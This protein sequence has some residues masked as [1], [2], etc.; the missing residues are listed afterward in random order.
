VVLR[1]SVL[2]LQVFPI[3]QQVQSAHPELAPLIR[4][5]D[6][7]MTIVVIYEALFA[8]HPQ[9]MC[10]KADH[11]WHTIWQRALSA[12]CPPFG[13]AVFASP[14]E[15]QTLPAHPT[16]SYAQSVKA[17]C[18]EAFAGLLPVLE[19][20][21]ARRPG[22][23]GLFD[24]TVVTMER[25]KWAWAVQSRC[26][27]DVQAELPAAEAASLHEKMAAERATS[28]GLVAAPASASAAEASA[29]ARGGE[30][31]GKP[32]RARARRT[33]LR[34]RMLVA[35]IVWTVPPM[36]CVPDACACVLRMNPS[37]GTVELVLQEAC[38]AGQ[39]LALAQ[40]GPGKSAH[41]AVASVGVVPP[42]AAV[43]HAAFRLLTSPLPLPAL[44]L[45]KVQQ[46]AVAKAAGVPWK[47]WPPEAIELRSD[48]SIEKQFMGVARA[49][50]C[51]SE[52]AAVCAQGR[53]HLFMRPVSPRNE[54][55]AL[56]LLAAS[57]QAEARNI[58][59]LAPPPPAS[60]PPAAPSASA[61]ASVSSET[62]S[63][64]ASAEEDSPPVKAGQ[65]DKEDATVLLARAQLW[66]TTRTLI[67]KAAA[68]AA[69]KKGAAAGGSS[70]PSAVPLPVASGS[71]GAW[72]SVPAELNDRRLRA[73]AGRGLLLRRLGYT[74]ARSGA[75]MT[76]VQFAAAALSAAASID[77]AEASKST[78]GESAAAQSHEAGSA[79][80]AAGADSEWET[81]RQGY[82]AAI[83]E[84]RDRALAQ[85]R[86]LLRGG[87]DTPAGGATTVAPEPA[88]ASTSGGS[89]GMLARAAA[90]AALATDREGAQ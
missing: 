68:K 61:S 41:S 27:V 46:Q 72:A 77:E 74:E 56:R 78:P 71:A 44:A 88:P 5:P 82:E 35:P 90:T 22:K 42:V 6:V 76:L 62:E 14:K 4:D 24:S 39:P 8:A 34:G 60:S 73:A 1:A 45:S 10:R 15:L 25:W 16:R 80:A 59:A 70:V 55:C 58:T 36:S 38:R 13:S 51:D 63:A 47:H 67:A 3:L 65:F 29:S 26:G 57:A 79:D 69:P 31:S 33:R 43:H 53:H 52:D 50:V 9:A 64:A 49:V 21:C 19:L 17:R 85:A 7:H 89:R 86:A 48:R 87:A 81:R 12:T 40:G 83:A 66:G 20:E 84:R 18:E 32:A 11:G 23:R 2:A 30:G 54:V 75:K 28:A 37:A